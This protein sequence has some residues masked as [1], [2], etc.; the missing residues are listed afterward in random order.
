MPAFDLLSAIFAVA[1]GVSAYLSRR[2]VVK[3]SE[4][5]DSDDKK[6][7]LR[8]EA[9]YLQW[10]VFGFPVLFIAPMATIP[11]VV[12]LISLVLTIA[13][14]VN[15]IGNK[16]FI[17]VLVSSKMSIIGYCSLALALIMD[18]FIILSICF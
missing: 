9:L 15:I 6:T 17:K 3:N 10:F 4:L 12:G 13:G 14:A 11:N 16:L 2:I 18:V 8:L 5:L 1:Y 7:L